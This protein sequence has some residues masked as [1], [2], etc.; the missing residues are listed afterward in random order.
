MGFWMQGNMGGGDFSHPFPVFAG[1]GVARVGKGLILADMSVEP[2]IGRVP[3]GGD[4]NNAQPTL[5]IDATKSNDKGESWVCVEVTPTPEG[6]L[7]E[8][9]SG[10][11]KVEVVQRDSPVLTLGDIGRWPLALL[12]FREQAVQVFQ[13]TMFHLH[14]ETSL[15]EGQRRKHF[16]I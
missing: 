13:V 16:F 11:S 7:K 8:S 14:Y 5:K 6:T 4:E 2:V 12:V 9:E 15:A 3:I 10:T 1:G